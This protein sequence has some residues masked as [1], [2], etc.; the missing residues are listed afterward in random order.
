MTLIDASFLY[1]Y[2]E[3]G[4]WNEDG[5]FTNGEL[6]TQEIKG[7]IHPLKSKE[8]LNYSNGT[9][10]T[11]YVK[12]ISSSKLKVKGRDN[13]SG[14]FIK[15]ENDLYMIE[16]EDAHSYLIPHYVYIANIIP[17]N[18]IPANVKNAFNL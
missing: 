16:K 15:K 10:S 12:I 2:F 8:A 4:V 6:V 18:E 3:K 1:A 9:R 11:G 7:T 14:G 17:D 13:E 5:T